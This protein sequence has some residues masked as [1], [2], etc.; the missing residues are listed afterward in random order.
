MSGGA[1]CLREEDLNSLGWH[2][3]QEK[4]TPK[5]K[6]L[7]AREG[8]LGEKTPCL[9]LKMTKDNYNLIENE[10]T[11]IICKMMSLLLDKRNNVKA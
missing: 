11:D 2:S 5:S 7:S 3:T 8:H 9:K 10:K 4:V 1:A 6:P